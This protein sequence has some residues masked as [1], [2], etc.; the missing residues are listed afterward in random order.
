MFIEAPPSLKPSKKYCDITGFEVNIIKNIKDKI[1][2]PINKYILPW[3][4]CI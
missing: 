1:Q 3:S 4:D 2:G